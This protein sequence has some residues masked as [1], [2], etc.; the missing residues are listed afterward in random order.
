MDTM[1]RSTTPS[2][3][4]DL[5]LA[6]TGSL[7]VRHDDKTGAVKIP[8]NGFPPLFYI[9]NPSDPKRCYTIKSLLSSTSKDHSRLVYLGEHEETKTRVTIIAASRED[10]AMRREYTYLENLR[11]VN[12]VA[13]RI[14]TTFQDDWCLIAREYAP[15]NIQ[16]YL[17]DRSLVSAKPSYA[18]NIGELI[19]TVATTLHALHGQGIVYRNLN[20][21][22]IHA[23]GIE[24]TVSYGKGKTSRRIVPHKTVLTNFRNAI[25]LSEAEFNPSGAYH[26]L[27]GAEFG[28]PEMYLGEITPASD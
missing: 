26:P 9:V 22:T 28:A 2:P 21:S 14:S 23:R 4:T 24:E 27:E 13:R 20:Q 25:R 1:T 15:F 11:L 19:D 18:F 17:H 6:D 8:P 10:A 7:P 5:A 16:E 3:I 12:G